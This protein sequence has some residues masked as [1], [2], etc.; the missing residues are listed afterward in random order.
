DGLLITFC[1]LSPRGLG[2]GIAGLPAVEP[3]GEEDELRP[4]RRFQWAGLLAGSGQPVLGA[5][6]LIALNS[7]YWC[8][9]QLASGGSALLNLDAELGLMGAY[10]LPLSGDAHSLIPF[11]SGFLVNDTKHNR[12]NYVKVEPGKPEAR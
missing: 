2:L 9:V 12:V 7:E 3:T 8:V 1:N 5:T 11:D 10:G 6:G 4:V